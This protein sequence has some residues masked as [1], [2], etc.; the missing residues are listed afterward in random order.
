LKTTFFKQTLAA[1]TFL[2]LNLAS[3]QAYAAQQISID[4]KL[5]EAAWKNAH[6][7]EAFKTFTGQPSVAPTTG[8]MM[9][10]E[11]HLY[12]A[13]HCEE[14]FMDKLE[15]TKLARD[16]NI[17]IN[18][19]IEIFI[20]PFQHQPDDYYQVIVDTSGQIYDAF[21]HNGHQDIN[22]DLSVTAKVQKNADSWTVEMALPLAQ[23]GLLQGNGARI[24]FG[25]ERKPVNEITSW[26]GTFRQPATWRELPLKRSAPNDVVIR[27]W[28]HG[29]EV[30]EYGNNEFNLEFTTAPGHVLEMELEALEKGHWTTKER[31]RL[32][33]TAAPQ[34]KWSLPYQLL[35]K[36]GPQNLRS[37]LRVNRRP[38]LELEY[39][40]ALPQ[41]AL[42][43]TPSV[44][45]QYSEE[46]QAL[47]QFKSYLT[48]ADLLKSR[49]LLK[50][51]SP[52]GKYVTRTISQV[53]KSMLISLDVSGWGTGDGQVTAELITDNQLLAKQNFVINKRPGPFAQSS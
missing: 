44:P 5:D 16:G 25:R 24:N 29:M 2:L 18:D 39:R 37:T 10:D 32:R 27:N 47:V 20:A 17:W 12:L 14:P 11:K 40:L 13:F 8:M 34:T 22:Y 41:E 43:A 52:D 4:G 33:T 9:W 6:P 21:K 3:S 51:Q 26:Q 48:D 42:T 49:L 7:I 35:P 31:Y 50:V 19:C 38:V 28:K 30:P 46:K 36:D 45:Y 15:A 53:R 1:T 23:V